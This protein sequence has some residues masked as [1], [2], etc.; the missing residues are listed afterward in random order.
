MRRV[1]WRL[2][3]NEENRFLQIA[4]SGFNLWWQRICDLSTACDFGK[5]RWRLWYNS[6]FGEVR[7]QCDS[8]I[9]SCF[10]VELHC[11]SLRYHYILVAAGYRR[12]LQQLFLTYLRKNCIESGSPWILWDYRV[13]CAFQLVF[14]YHSHVWSRQVWGLLAHL[15]QKSEYRRQFQTLH[16]RCESSRMKY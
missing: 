2:R 7:I 14:Q 3:R 1:V 10:H 5:I 15:V 9:Q 6:W 4:G 16:H 13:S 11:W 8:L 12:V